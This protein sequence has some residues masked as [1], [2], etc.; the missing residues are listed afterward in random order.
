MPRQSATCNPR[1]VTIPKRLF[2]LGFTV[3]AM[4][5]ATSWHGCQGPELQA[6]ALA[7]NVRRQAVM[8]A[9]ALAFAQ[10]YYGNLSQD[11]MSTKVEIIDD[12]QVSSLSPIMIGGEGVK[13]RRRLIVD[14]DFPADRPNIFGFCCHFRRMRITNHWSKTISHAPCFC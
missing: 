1:F 3:T 9:L 7:S 14:R 11:G 5:G 6:T 2:I 12:G 8:Q 10:K 4:L 13:L